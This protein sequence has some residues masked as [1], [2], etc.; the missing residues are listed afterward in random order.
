MGT[1]IRPQKE[2]GHLTLMAITAPK[3]APDSAMVVEVLLPAGRNP[4][5]ATAVPLVDR[6]ELDHRRISASFIGMDLQTELHL[7]RWLE[8]L[9][10]NKPPVRS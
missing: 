9:G 7:A 4:I 10:R 2:Y 6:P 8:Q 5:R 1:A 3:P